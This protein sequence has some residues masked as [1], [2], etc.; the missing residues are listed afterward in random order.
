MEQFWEHKTATLKHTAW[1][2][3]QK[4]PTCGFCLPAGGA[5][6]GEGNELVPERVIFRYGLRANQG[7]EAGVIRQVTDLAGVGSHLYWLH[8]ARLSSLHCFSTGH[9]TNPRGKQGAKRLNFYD[10]KG[11]SILHSNSEMC[12]MV[13]HSVPGVLLP[14]VV[15]LDDPTQALQ[16]LQHRFSPVPNHLF[17]ADQVKSVTHIEPGRMLCILE[18]PH[19]WHT[20]VT[21]FRRTRAHQRCPAMVNH[22]GFNL[23]E[24]HTAKLKGKNTWHQEM[25]LSRYVQCTDCNILQYMTS[26]KNT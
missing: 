14:C 20:G 18:M 26:S 16:N 9:I 15:P 11:A 8:S 12:Q 22:R 17:I 6:K 7:L 1:Q 5:D 21:T 10:G 23:H 13:H 3:W 19:L 25:L 24:R 4:F 2:I